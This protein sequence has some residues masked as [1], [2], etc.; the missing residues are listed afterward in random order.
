[1]SSI[2][3]KNAEQE[4]GD[5]QAIRHE[6]QMG[7]GRQR[8][9]SGCLTLDAREDTQSSVGGIASWIF[10]SRPVF[11]SIGEMSPNA[12]TLGG[13]LKKNTLHLGSDLEYDED[14]ASQL[15]GAECSCN[16]TSSIC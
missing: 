3:W 9:C 6:E 1:M 4:G 16:A 8:F 5:W 15:R 7:G 10:S 12:V 2:G 14:A 11:K 13:N